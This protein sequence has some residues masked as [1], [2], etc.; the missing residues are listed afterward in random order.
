[1][2]TANA[3]EIYHIDLD[4]GISDLTVP[5]GSSGIAIEVNRGP[6]PVGFL[7]APYPPGTA[8]SAPDIETWIR[9]EVTEECLN[10]PVTSVSSNAPMPKVTVAVCTKDHPDLL[11]RCLTALTR[12][13]IPPGANKPDI[14]VVDNASKTSETRDVAS[15][16]GD[17][18]YVL[19][20]KTGLNFARNRALRE[21]TGEILAFIDDDAVVDVTW[22]TGLSEAWAMEPA[23]GAFAGQTLPLKLETEAQIV[24]ETMG[25]F[26]KG[27][28]PIVF[29]KEHPADPL[30][31]CSTAFGNGCNMAFKVDVMR[32]IGGFDIA[33]DMGAALPGGGDLD[34]LYSVVRNGYDLV[35]E[36]KM[37]V[38]H[39]HRR[40]M[41]GL[42]RQIRR[43][44]GIGCM[45]FLTKIR[46][47]DP[48]MNVKAR[49]FIR[50]WMKDMMRELVHPM[51]KRRTMPKALLLQQFIGAL[52]ALTGTYDRCKTIAER[53]S[54]ANA[55]S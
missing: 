25:G 10:Q 2:S 52:I 7:L 42:R 54:S 40:D 33:L 14:L 47:T 55:E 39:E 29:R 19:E 49:H 16:F 9:R 51:P 5:E 43:S 46:D 32:K 13:A 17:V 28:L 34:A 20:R 41:A 3:Y 31:P 27:F 38:R 6:R 44:W 8:F 37:L 4:E 35:Y 50:W 15:S 1:M 21:A 12:M 23:A 36:P 11:K 18:R 26:R 45:A 48:E 30:Y 53:I 24:V 22:L